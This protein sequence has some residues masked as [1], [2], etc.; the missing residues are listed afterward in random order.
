MKTVQKCPKHKFSGMPTRN[1]Q[2]SQVSENKQFCRYLSLIQPH[3]PR[4]VAIRMDSG[5][6]K[7]HIKM[8][9][10]WSEQIRRIEG[11]PK[12]RGLTSPRHLRL[13]CT[14][15]SF[16]VYRR[17][18]FTVQQ[19]ENAARW[20]PALF[21][22]PRPTHHHL[23]CCKAALQRRYYI[24]HLGACK[25]VQIC[26]DTQVLQEKMEKKKAG[27]ARHRSEDVA[28]KNAK[29]MEAD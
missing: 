28:S 22:T 15:V 14:I 17:L 21:F 19:E 4:E 3:Q 10:I 26:P 8:I 25:I 7:S 5:C 27:L 13:M 16:G 11:C 9:L 18:A 29:R 2:A 24:S 6:F 20:A 1:A 12:N 23:S